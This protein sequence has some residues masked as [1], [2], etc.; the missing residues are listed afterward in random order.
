MMVPL[1]SPRRVTCSSWTARSTW[2]PDL[3]IVHRRHLGMLRK[4]APRPPP[5]AARD[6][7]SETLYGLSSRGPL[8]GVHGTP[9]HRTQR[10]RARCGP[11]VL[12]PVWSRFQTTHQRLDQAPHSL[13]STETALITARPRAGDRKALL[14]SG[15][16]P[17]PCPALG[18]V[19]RSSAHRGRPAYDHRQDVRL[20]QVGASDSASSA[21]DGPPLLGRR[22]RTCGPVADQAKE[23]AHDADPGHS[24]HPQLTEPNSR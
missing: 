18:E 9:G 15:A 4:V 2:P 6:L 16:H 21:W 24:G 23:T 3:R 13:D 11:P 17:T 8:V 22:G 5:M 19:K 12:S 7:G 14:A 1:G 20:V 10:F